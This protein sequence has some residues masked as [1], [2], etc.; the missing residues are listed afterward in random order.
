VTALV[1]GALVAGVAVWLAARPT[2]PR[3]VRTEITTSADAVLAMS[4]ADRDLAITPDGSRIVYRGRNQLLV[5]ALDRLEPTPLTGLGAPRG[6]FVSPDGQWVGFND[7]NTATLRKVALTGGPPVT[8][9]TLDSAIRGATWSEDGTIIYSTASPATGLRRVSAAG[10]EAMVLTTPDRERGE[11]D[12]VWPEF[13]PGG[14][15][16]LYTITAVVGGLEGAQI[17]VLDLR[18]STQTVLV[19]GGSHAHYVP[20]GHLVY[21]A[22]GTVRAVAFDLARLTVTGTPVPVV[23]R[24]QTTP[25]G[26]VDA[27]VAST[28][29]LAYIAGGITTAVGSTLAWLDRQG[30]AEALG[31]PPRAYAAY[32]RLSPDGQRVAVVVDDDVWVFDVTRRTLTRLT[33]EGGAQPIWS[34]DG[35]YITYRK[36]RGKA[37]SLFWK[38]ADGTG[39]EEQLTTGLRDGTSSWS[40]DGQVLGFYDTLDVSGGTDRDIWILPRTGD[41]KPKPFLQTPFNEAA[42]MFSPDGRWVAYVSDESGRNEVY[43]LPFPGPGGKWQIS[44]DGGGD[45]VW[46]RNG[47]ELFYLNGTQ[48]MAVDV[49]T[50]PTFRAGTPRRLFDGGFV[51]GVGRVPVYDVTPDGQRFL[52]VGEQAIGAGEAAPVSIVVVENWLEELKRI[53][54]AN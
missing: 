46:S 19:R 52:M 41:R 13:L 16:V 36:T 30:K 34:P 44:T 51:T 25:T 18:T 43:V 50:S 26:A 49:E 10:G 28:G 32:P 20:T 24:V 7:A 39:V 23:E 45:P 3:I 42:L 15:A 29:A 21:G 22:G 5:R 6:V 2:P 17:A 37:Q 1:L 35:Q 33:F 9:T 53:V 48:M 31:A 11:A 40:P 38:R 14:Q 27:V 12:H 47:R 4:G 54:P 8:L